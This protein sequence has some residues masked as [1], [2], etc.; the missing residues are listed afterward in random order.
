MDFLAKGYVLLDGGK[1][2]WEVHNRLGLCY[3]LWFVLRVCLGKPLKGWLTAP[4]KQGRAVLPQSHG[5]VRM[6][7]MREPSLCGQATLLY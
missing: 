1:V 3:C 5:L 4:G 6:A 2:S 7:P